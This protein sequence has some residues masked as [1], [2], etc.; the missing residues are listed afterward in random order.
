MSARSS[1]PFR[2]ASVPGGA[3][4]CLV[5]AAPTLAVVPKTTRV[6]VSSAEGQ[7]NS[8]SYTSSI[9]GRRPLR[10]LPLG[11]QRPRRQRH[12]RHRGRLR[13]RPPGGHHL[14]GSPSA[15]RGL[16]GTAQQRARPSQR[17]AATSPSSLPRATSSPA[18]RTAPSTSSCATGRRAPLKRVSISSAGPGERLQP[19]RRPSRPTAATFAFDSDA[20]DLVAGD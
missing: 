11:R 18:T 17:T 6:S 3:P 1:R 9:S 16:Q 8:D 12:E 7:G 10:R 13:V 20:T 15:P 14:S 5:V 4:A 19:Y 2:L